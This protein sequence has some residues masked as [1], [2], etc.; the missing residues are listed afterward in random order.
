M[1]CIIA[2]ARATTQPGSTWRLFTEQH[3]RERHLNSELGVGG[4][5]SVPNSPHRRATS[6]LRGTGVP[7]ASRTPILIYNSRDTASG[8]LSWPD[9]S[10]TRA[11]NQR[12]VLPLSLATTSRW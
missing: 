12:F 2:T 4:A 5:D 8:S 10:H 6:W 7:V 3:G 1:R 11:S 9:L